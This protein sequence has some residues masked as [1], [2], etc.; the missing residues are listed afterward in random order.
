MSLFI[1]QSLI[2]IN[3]HTWSVSRSKEPDY[4]IHFNVW[5]FINK[6][7]LVWHITDNQECIKQRIKLFQIIIHYHMLERTIIVK[8]NIHDMLNMYLEGCGVLLFCRIKSI[9]F[10]VNKLILQYLKARRCKYFTFY[11]LT[12]CT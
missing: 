8:L 9:T 5:N 2:L 6:V 11:T 12:P 4:V 7:S 3:E 1:G 10:T